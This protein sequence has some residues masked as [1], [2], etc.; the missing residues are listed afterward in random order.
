MQGL[1]FTAWKLIARRAFYLET[2]NGGVARRQ[3]LLPPLSW[4]AAASD[5]TQ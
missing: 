4:P 2:A 1:S 5:H 3:E